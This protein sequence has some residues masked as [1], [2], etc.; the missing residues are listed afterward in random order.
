[1]LLLSAIFVFSCSTNQASIDAVN[2]PSAETV[3][4]ESVIEISAEDRMANEIDE[5]R[6]CIGVL[7][8]VI[9]RHQHG[10][11]DG[12]TN[13]SADDFTDLPTISRSYSFGDQLSVSGKID[14]SICASALLSRQ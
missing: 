4:T 14:E 1:M 11:N 7:I 5:L 10:E 13:T 9:T 8:D 6:S 2:E 3:L 12:T